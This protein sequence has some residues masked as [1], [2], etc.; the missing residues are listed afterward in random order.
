M[1]HNTDG[2]NIHGKFGCNLIN[3]TGS[4]LYNDRW[5]DAFISPFVPDLFDVESWQST[6]IECKQRTGFTFYVDWKFGRGGANNEPKKPLQKYF[7]LKGGDIKRQGSWNDGTTLY[8]GWNGGPGLLTK[9]ILSTCAIDGVQLGFCLPDALL[10]K[11][12][13]T[14]KIKTFFGEYQMGMSCFGFKTEA[15]CLKKDT[16][17]GDS[18]TDGTGLGTTGGGSGN[19]AYVNGE[20]IPRCGWLNDQAG[21][22]ESPTTREPTNSP[23]PASWDS[24]SGSNDAPSSC[25]DNTNQDDCLS[26]EDDCYW[27]SKHSQACAGHQ[28]DNSILEHGF[29]W[30]DNDDDGFLGLNA[31]TGECE[32]CVQLSSG[33]A[34]AEFEF[35][36]GMEQL[37]FL[38]R[39][40]GATC[41]IDGTDVS[42]KILEFGHSCPRM[43][44]YANGA[45]EEYVFDSP[46]MRK[47]I[48]FAALGFE[49]WS[50]IQGL[51]W[52]CG[53]VEYSGASTASP[54]LPVLAVLSALLFKWR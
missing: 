46:G 4:F 41:T 12:N 18:R 40:E 1:P 32:P 2:S 5:R 42:V 50:T 48:E 3:T 15:E 54:V 22:T 24:D 9:E 44:H 35:D 33:L 17:S 34:Q 14:F 53:G 19:F 45:A 6:D 10:A 39:N 49:E 31:T 52:S 43:Q 36:K 25:Y 23:T 16:F 38:E 26:Y 27:V 21:E 20:E 13:A 8:G 30:D 11:D 28:V 7:E 37:L 47:K 29:D 51:E